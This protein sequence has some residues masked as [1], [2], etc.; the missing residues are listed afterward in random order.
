MPNYSGKWSLPT[1]MQAVAARKIGPILFMEA[2]YTS[3]GT[4]SW[5]APAKVTSVSVVAVGGGGAYGGGG[6]G[7][8]YKNGYIAGTPGNSYTVLVGTAPVQRQGKR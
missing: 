6:G 8:G 4:Y 5:V 2:A 1:V 3:T 7:L